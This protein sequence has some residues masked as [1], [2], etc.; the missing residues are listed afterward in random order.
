MKKIKHLK[1]KHSKLI[2]PVVGEVE[3]E[4]NEV[5]VDEQVAEQLVDNVNWAYVE[6]EKGDED[7][8]KEESDMTEEEKAQ[9]SDFLKNATFQELVSVASESNIVNWQIFNKEEQAEK[10]RTLLIKKLIK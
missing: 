5:E 8:N 1:G 4:N 3:L 6:S 7:Q 10:L 9:F 2:L